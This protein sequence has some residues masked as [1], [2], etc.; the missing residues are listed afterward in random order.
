MDQRDFPFSRF[1]QFS[2]LREDFAVQLII[3]F[4]MLKSYKCLPVYVVENH[5]EALQHIY[6]AMGSRHLPL[7]GVVMVHL[8][9][10]PDLMISTDMKANVVCNKQALF[11]NLSIENWIMPAMYS[12]HLHHV[13]WVKPPWANQLELGQTTFH[14]GTHSESQKIRV[15]WPDS[16]FLSD[17]LFATRDELQ[18]AKK[19]KVSVVD[20]ETP[21]LKRAT[22]QEL[23]E[24]SKEL[25]RKRLN[26]GDRNKTKESVT[27]KSQNEHDQYKKNLMKPSVTDDQGNHIDCKTKESTSEDIIEKKAGSA[28]HKNDSGEEEIIS[29]HSKLIS[30]ESQFEQTLGS[31]HTDSVEYMFEIISKAIEASKAY[32]LDIDLDFFSTKNPFRELY[33]EEQ[34]DVLKSLY[35]FVGP[36]DDSI[37]AIHKCQEVRT[38]QLMELEMALKSCLQVIP[39]TDEVKQFKCYQEVSNLLINIQKTSPEP[40]DWELIHAAGMSCDNTDPE[41]PHHVSTVEEINSLL[42]AAESLFTRLPRPTLIT[43]SRSS[44]DDYCPPEQVDMI[45]QKTLKMLQ[46]VFGQIDVHLDYENYNDD[47]S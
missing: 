10:H 28:T 36:E 44:Y 32:I 7:D 41:L 17:V 13:V 11:E 45:Q 30:S 34:Y 46:T 18:N 8:D 20:L 25:N 16:Y 3:G 27:A 23:E 29:N 22:F 6:R 43:M 15:T 38:L 4:K 35:D 42:A 37:S 24:L 40:L 33:T 5:Q 21:L 31:P 47:E 9:A 12:G 14:I 2:P 1:L 39:L 26:Y 19:V